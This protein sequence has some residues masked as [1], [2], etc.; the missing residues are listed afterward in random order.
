MFNRMEDLYNLIWH[1]VKGFRADKLSYDLG[2]L[3]GCL[4][5]E[6]LYLIDSKTLPTMFEELTNFGSKRT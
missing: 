3:W 6:K 1:P 4:K 2:E 5:I